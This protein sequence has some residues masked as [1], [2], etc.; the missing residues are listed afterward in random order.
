MRSSCLGVSDYGRD[1]PPQSL[2]PCSDHLGGD[3]QP[4]TGVGEMGGGGGAAA[5]SRLPSGGCLLKR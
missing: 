1:A 4:Q 5:E 2:Y 3:D